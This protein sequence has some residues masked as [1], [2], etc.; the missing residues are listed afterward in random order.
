ME[1]VCT[2]YLND[3]TVNLAASDEKKQKQDDYGF[4]KKTAWPKK[5]LHETQIKFL[6]QSF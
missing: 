1:K 6:L 4:S 3:N 5:K 2:N